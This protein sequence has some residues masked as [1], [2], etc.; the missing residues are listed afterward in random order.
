MFAP[1]PIDGFHVTSSPPCWWTKTK[2]LSLAS[3]VRPP[4]VVRFSIVIGVSR[5]WLKTSYMASE[6][7][8]R[9]I[10]MCFDVALLHRK[11]L[12]ASLSAGHLRPLH[13]SPVDRAGR[14]SEISP[15]L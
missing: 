4:E 3:F 7:A 14:V 10:E 6:T 2:D 8:K 13:M 12:K 15:Y 11:V 5:D 9:S 1:Q